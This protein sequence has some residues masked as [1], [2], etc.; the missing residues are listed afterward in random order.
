MCINEGMINISNSVQLHPPLSP[1]AEKDAFKVYK[2]KN[3]E[4]KWSGEKEG[5]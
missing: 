2:W 1:F 3:R 4:E 5:D